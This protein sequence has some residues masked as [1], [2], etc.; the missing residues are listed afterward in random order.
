MSDAL[1]SMRFRNTSNRDIASHTVSYGVPLPAGALTQ[2]KGLAVALEDGKL[3]P[4]QTRVLESHADGSIKW[5]LLDFD[6]P[7]PRN[8]TVRADLVK[9][10]ARAGSKVVKVEETDKRITIT[11]PKLEVVLSKKVFSLFESYKVNG[12]QMVGPDSDILVEEP[13][14]KRFYASNAKNLVVKVVE[15][16]PQKVVIESSGRHTAGDGAE[17]L[18]FRVRHVFRANE[19]GV[20]VS[21]KFSNA[22]MPETGVMLGAIQLLLPT[23]LGKRTVHTLRQGNHGKLWFSRF[24]EAPENVEVLASGALNAAAKERY[25]AAAEG[26][27]LVRDLANLREK[28]G[29]YP[30]FLRPGN[31][32]TDMTG[33]LRHVYPYIA[34][35]GPEKSLISFFFDMSCNY[36]K[37]IRADRGMMT[38]DIWPAFA[39]EMQLRRGMSK[40]HDLYFAFADRQRT[41]EEMEAV[42]FDREIK[43]SL[44]VHVTLDP[45]YV[46]SCEVL[47]LHRWLAYDEA[48]YLAVE[49]KLGSAGGQGDVN[50]APGSKGMFDIGDY[51]SPNRSWAHNNEDDAILN[52]I[53]EYYRLEAPG[54]LRGSLMNARHNSTVD[55]IAFDPDPLRQGTMPAHC[56]EHTDGATYP[57]HMWADGL[58]AAYCLTGNEDFKAAAFSVGENMLRWQRD[59]PDIFYAD[60]RECGWPALAFCRLYE[61]SREQRWPGALF[62]HRAHGQRGG[63]GLPREV[64]GEGLQ[65][66]GRAHGRRLG[67][68]R[69]VPRLGALQAHR[70]EE[71]PRGQL[72]VPALPDGA[73]RRVP[74]GRERHALLLE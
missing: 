74:L 35:N 37:A 32:R 24:V 3:R 41:A 63:E 18:G 2:A 39:G 8:A 20:K 67:L 57:S 22:E 64:P 45:A 48:K 10:V 7:V 49:T 46:R 31:A 23:T 51:I 59:C 5:L 27:P 43:E 38:Y 71:V 4:L 72:P 55:L 33:G 61:H 44:P 52:G 6:L 53:R 69:H 66:P 26:I 11:T 54:R 40:E 25:G 14:G 17:L 16:G 28:L 36:P 12:K 58:M 21:Y 62:L 1:L 30:Y 70:R 65:V 34:A 15:A 73:P 47:H 13:K 50:Y 9:G 42:Y 19:P 56:P 29:D 60:S 68:Q